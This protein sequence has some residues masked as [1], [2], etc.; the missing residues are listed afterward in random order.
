MCSR[1]GEASGGTGTEGRGKA[2][3]G[4]G[5]G[6]VGRNQSPQVWLCQPRVRTLP[7]GSR[8]PWK[9]MGRRTSSSD[10]HLISF[11]ISLGEP[12]LVTS[13][14]A[15]VSL[16]VKWEVRSRK[17]L[18]AQIFCTLLGLW[19]TSS[20]LMINSQPLGVKSSCSALI[21]DEDAGSFFAVHTLNTHPSSGVLS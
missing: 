7:R 21:P 8:E 18:A 15:S 4:F 9:V 11:T 1:N 6:E 14:W 16:Y 2:A 12:E 20:G 17:D 5:A 19:V 3:G 13:I 10:S